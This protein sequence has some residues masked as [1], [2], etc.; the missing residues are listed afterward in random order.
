MKLSNILA[1]FVAI[2]TAYATETSKNVIHN[3]SL[4]SPYIDDGFHITNW[5][6]G[7]DAYIKADSGVILTTDLPSKRGWIWSTNTLPTEGWKIDFDFFI[8]NSKSGILNGDGFAFW[9]TQ[10]RSTSGPV[11]GSRDYFT[12]LGLFFD[13]YPN[14]NHGKSFPMVVGMVGDGKTSYD[15][16]SD[17]TVGSTGICQGIFVRNLDTASTCT[18]TYIPKKLLSVKIFYMGQERTCFS[19]TGITLPDNLFLGFS[20]ITGQLSGM[21]QYNNAFST[22]ILLN[23][24]ILLFVDVHRITRV[25]V[26]KL[27]QNEINGLTSNVTRFF[28]TT[29]CKNSLN[30][31]SL[32]TDRLG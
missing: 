12:G 23:M 14:G 20:A 1:S 8:G 2:S 21:S 27:D 17:G 30:P 11:F 3:F 25:Q 22:N 24:T 31:S 28:I 5:D 4:D 7:G 16:S 15:G 32:Q 9:A 6:F 10:E 13:T 29:L 26:A 18:I 19:R